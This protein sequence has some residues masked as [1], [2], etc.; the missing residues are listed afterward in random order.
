MASPAL[1]VSRNAMYSHKSVTFRSRYI[2]RKMP[3][4]GP[5]QFWFLFKFGIIFAMPPSVPLSYP[6][7]LPSFSDLI[8]TVKIYTVYS[9]I[10]VQ[11]FLLFFPFNKML[12]ISFYIVNY[13]ARLLHC[14]RLSDISLYGCA[15]IYLTIL[16]LG[17]T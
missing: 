5:K 9:E 8:L 13:R 7:S 15:I 16:L 3:T 6:P 14:W 2:Q 12:G 10:T 17:T 4:T 1:V 11:C